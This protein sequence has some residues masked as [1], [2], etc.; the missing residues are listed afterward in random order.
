VSGVIAMWLVG[1]LVATAQPI[2]ECRRGD[3][4]RNVLLFGLAVS[5][6]A[7][8]L[9]GLAPAATHPPDVHGDLKQGAAAQAA[10]ASAARGLLVVGEIAISRSCCSSVRG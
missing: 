2:L 5:T 10:S 3:G 6:L 7:G 1:P 4:D 9:F 8:L